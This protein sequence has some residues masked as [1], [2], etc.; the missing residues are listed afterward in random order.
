MSGHR[1]LLSPELRKQSVEHGFHQGA[2]SQV[3]EKLFHDETK[4]RFF[5]AEEC[6]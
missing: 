1:S 3:A 2:S 5:G 4:S 6:A